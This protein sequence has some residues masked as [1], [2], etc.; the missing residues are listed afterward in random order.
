MTDSDR[1]ELENKIVEMI[2]T[3]D[4]ELNIPV[5]CA[6]LM[7]ESMDMAYKIMP[8]ERAF[9]SIMRCAKM[10]ARTHGMLIETELR[11]EK[12]H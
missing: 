3:M 5:C 9:D 11:K 10:V 4:G 7:Y 2:K 8:P 12:I 1:K 6:A